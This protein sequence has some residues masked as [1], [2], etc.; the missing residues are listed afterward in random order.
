MINI[1]YDFPNYEVTIDGHAGSKPKGE[2]IYCAGISSLT[3]ALCCALKNADQQGMIDGLKLE[4]EEGHSH[5][6]AKPTKDCEPIVQTIFTTIFNGFDAMS[7]SFPEYVSF[8]QRG[9]EKSA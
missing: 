7:V 8:E 6:V 3:M 5:I 1:E 9:V 2:D 4:L